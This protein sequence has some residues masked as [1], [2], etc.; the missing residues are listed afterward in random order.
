VSNRGRALLRAQLRQ[1]LPP[2]GAP[3]RFL[4][5]EGPE[6]LRA[7]ADIVAAAPDV[8]RSV[9]ALR[10]APLAIQLA[11]WRA[12]RRAALQVRLMYREL[13]VFFVPMRARRRLL[14]PDR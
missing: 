8:I 7:W 10:L 1:G 3:P 12:G 4:R 11:D 13:G 9:D 2:L 14:F 5:R 6:A